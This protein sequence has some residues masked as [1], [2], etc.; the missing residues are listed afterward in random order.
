[1]Q[2]MGNERLMYYSDGTKCDS[3]LNFEDTELN[4]MNWIQTTLFETAEDCCRERFWWDIA[5]CLDESPKEIQFTFS[6]DIHGVSE[7]TNCQDAD[8]IANAM[9]D[10][11]NVGWNDVN[12]H[13]FVTSIGNVE[14]SSASDGTTECG[15]SLAGTSYAGS[16]DPK[17]GYPLDSSN[18]ITMAFEVSAKSSTCFDDACFT[19][20]FNQL[21]TNFSL[22]AG[23]GQFTTQIR[24]KASEQGVSALLIAAADALSLVFGTMKTVE[25]VAAESKSGKWYPNW[26]ANDE[27]HKLTC[28]NDGREPTYMKNNAADYL[29]DSQEACCETWFSWKDDCVSSGDAASTDLYYY[30]SWKDDTCSRK[31]EQEFKYWETDDKFTTLDECCSSRFGWNLVA[32]CGTPGMGG[33]TATDSSSTVYSP[34]WTARSCSPRNKALLEP[35]EIT[36]AE[37]SANLC[38]IRHFNWEKNC[39]LCPIW[40]MLES[41]WLSFALLLFK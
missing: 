25:M 36:F 34:D 18:V 6:L 28:S 30:P 24:V 5:G 17:D 38:C 4:S 35:W 9:Q 41:S 33:C 37:S 26:M 8:R 32:C 29:F 22:Y 20:L 21:V 23:Y 15:G 27:S 31:Q 13:A 2:C 16:Y 11:A 7:P 12:T 19:A 10:A 40:W 39:M 3:K 1:M 14:L